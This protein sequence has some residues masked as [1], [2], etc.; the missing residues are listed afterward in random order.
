ML[1]YLV[2]NKINGKQYVGQTTKT[3]EARWFDH[4]Q[5]RKNPSCKY[6]YSAIQKYG[7]ENFQV[8]TLVIVDSK[9]EMDRNE[10]GL[11]AALGTKAPKGYNLTDGGDGAQGFVFT[12]E[13]RNKISRGL[14]GRRMSD[15][16]RTK[17]L[18]RNKGNKFSLGVKMPE[19]HRLKLININKGRKQSVEE[20]AKRSAAQKGR[21]HSEE[22]KR[23]MSESAKRRYT[24]K[25]FKCPSTIES[26]PPTISKI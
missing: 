15:K 23:K 18:E 11:I 13:Q 6:L 24:N 17:L 25:E 16:A 21:R 20:R 12:L 7:V 2:T 4:N 8:E 14:L 1:V 26:A 3:L 9:E 19:E 10:R 22:T 5:T